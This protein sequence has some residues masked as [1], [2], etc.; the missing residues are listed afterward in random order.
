LGRI[1]E[2][3]EI[4]ALVHYVRYVV[5]DITRRYVIYAVKIGCRIQE[6]INMLIIRLCSAYL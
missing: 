3:Q 6:I 2:K 4:I 1:L 5:T